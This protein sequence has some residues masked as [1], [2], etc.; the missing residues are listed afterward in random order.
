MKIISQTLLKEIENDPI[1]YF[2]DQY[3]TDIEVLLILGEKDAKYPSVYYGPIASRWMIDFKIRERTLDHREKAKNNIAEIIQTYKKLNNISEDYF[4]HAGKRIFQILA[5]YFAYLVFLPDER[6]DKEYANLNKDFDEE[7]FEDWINARGTI[8][9]F[10]DFLHSRRVEISEKAITERKR[11]DKYIQDYFRSHKEI[12]CDLQ[13]DSI[14]HKELYINS[15]ADI[16]PRSHWWYHLHE[17]D[18]LSKEDLKT[19]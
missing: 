3:Q 1:V 6:F 13:D 14:S 11:Q 19:I 7:Y 16:F 8:H 17:I 10:Y 4:S 2:L 12:Y 15:W 5:E 9:F 18:R